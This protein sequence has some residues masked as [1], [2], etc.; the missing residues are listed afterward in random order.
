MPKYLMLDHGGVL[1]GQQS[2]NPTENDLILNDYGD[3][4]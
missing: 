3:G 1:D 4:L 2:Q